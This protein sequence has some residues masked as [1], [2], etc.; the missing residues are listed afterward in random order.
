MDEVWAS[1]KFVGSKI[2][3]SNNKLGNVEYAAGS[4]DVVVAE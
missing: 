1:H 4:S 2:K 3:L